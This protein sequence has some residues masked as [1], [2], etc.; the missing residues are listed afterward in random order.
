MNTLLRLSVTL[1]LQIPAASCWASPPRE[2]SE[3]IAT[4]LQEYSVPSAAVAVI[5]NGNLEWSEAFGDRMYGTSASSETIFN[6]AS[7]TKPAFGMMILQLVEKGKLELDSPVSTFWVD[8]DVTESK[9]HKEI[10]PRIALS[11]Q[12]GFPNWRRKDKLSFL[13][14]PGTKHGYSGEGF[15]Y[16]RR[17][18]ERKTGES[19]AVLMERNVTSKAGMTDTYWG[20]NEEISG[21]L[22]T[23]YN[24]KGEPRSLKSLT[25]R[26]PNAAANMFTTI[27]DYGRFAQWVLAGA[28]LS[29]LMFE[30]MQRKQSLHPN[31]IDPFGLSWKLTQV[32]NETVIWHD[33]RETGLFT[34]VVLW[35]RRQQ[36][37][38]VFTNGEHGELVA[39]RIISESIEQGNAFLRSKHLDTWKYLLSIPD[40]ELAS[41]MNRIVK[42]PSFTRSLLD[43]IAYS[44]PPESSISEI[45]RAEARQLFDRSS[46]AMISMGLHPKTTSTIR[47]IVTD[48]R[49][50]SVLDDEQ[51]RSFVDMIRSSVNAKN[52]KLE[53]DVLKKYEGVYQ[54]EQGRW[55]GL[56]L[57]IQAAKSSL[58]VSIND[59]DDETAIPISETMFSV[60]TSH[61]HLEFIEDGS[62]GP[63]TMTIYAVNNQTLYARLV[64]A[65]EK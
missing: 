2:F 53:E 57:A 37:I 62:G 25:S 65:F 48:A 35:P 8:P 46:S 29:E 50:G 30:E 13:F 16:L 15:E 54:I 38:V 3:K 55:K 63:D 26:K 51:F 23:N 27:H 33:G 32:G 17:A 40:S 21:R 59:G 58:I 47:Q 14:E 36:G 52:M 39:Q 28:D 41:V 20:W 6:V 9:Y 5:V 61:M 43:G 11:H 42:T 56:T 12:T 64:K 49:N 19:L 44:L 60:P 31:P 45:E 7:L 10:T 18:I 22:A 4:W 1:A 34:Q 24:H